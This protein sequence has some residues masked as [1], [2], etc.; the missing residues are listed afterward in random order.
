MVQMISLTEGFMQAVYLCH[1]FKYKLI[2]HNIN[3]DS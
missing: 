1:L 2:R 3:S